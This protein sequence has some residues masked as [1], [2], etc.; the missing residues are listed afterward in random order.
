V[1]SVA[2]GVQEEEGQVMS[3]LSTPWHHTPTGYEARVTHWA[4]LAQGGPFSTLFPLQVVLWGS[5]GLSS[6]LRGS[7]GSASEFCGT[8]RAR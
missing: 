4:G 6:A 3:P 2:R 8:G 1:A 7:P 5:S